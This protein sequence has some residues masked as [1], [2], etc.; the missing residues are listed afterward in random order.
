MD[1]DHARAD[2]FSDGNSE[3]ECGDKVECSGPHNRQSRREYARRDY[4]GDAIRG[5]MKAIEEIEAQR[6]QNCKRHQQRR[7][8]H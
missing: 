6:E 2:G 5:V 8:I 4:S 3:D 1:I 7:G